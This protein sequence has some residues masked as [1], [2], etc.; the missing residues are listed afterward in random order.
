MGW[1]RDRREWAWMG[2]RAGQR[3]QWSSRQMG[4]A[5]ELG[6]GCEQLEEPWGL[7]AGGEF[8]GCDCRE[9]GGSSPAEN[10]KGP[11]W[12]VRISLLL[13]WDLSRAR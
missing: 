7:G 9:G 12:A 10:T 1:R 5:L 8:R 11:V 6:M 2:H 4:M 3:G 13:A